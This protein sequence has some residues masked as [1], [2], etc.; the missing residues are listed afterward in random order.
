MSSTPSIPKPA[1]GSPGGKASGNRLHD[2]HA[3]LRQVRLCWR[4][5]QGNQ[6][7]Q[8]RAID[9]SSFGMLVEADKAIPPGTV[10]SV[11]TN[12]KVIGKACVRHCTPKGARYR[13]GLHMPDRMMR[14]L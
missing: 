3:I 1:G 8:A 13:I 14:E 12:A 10:L 5:S 4:G 7:L 9:L 11:E 2:R 6:V